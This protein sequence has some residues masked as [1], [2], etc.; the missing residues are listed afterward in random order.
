MYVDDVERGF[1]ILRYRL[2]LFPILRY[3]FALFPRFMLN[4]FVGSV[5]EEGLVPRVD[6]ALRG[7]ARSSG[8]RRWNTDN[9]SPHLGRS[10][11]DHI[12]GR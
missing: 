11:C 10:T 7:S 8:S 1:P 12:S 9:T 4:R 3:R 2:A 5:A 6:R